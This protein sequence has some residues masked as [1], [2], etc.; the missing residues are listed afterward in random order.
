MC[1]N[2]AIKH[3]DQHGANVAHNLTSRTRRADSA[4]AGKR[5]ICVKIQSFGYHTDSC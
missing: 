4:G 5:K 3:G 1:F 2:M